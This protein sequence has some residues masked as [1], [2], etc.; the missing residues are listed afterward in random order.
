MHPILLQLAAAAVP[1]LAT[2]A[3]GF[4]ARQKDQK[5]IGVLYG[6]LAEVQK[7]MPI[8]TGELK[9]IEH[10]G[11]GTESIAASAYKTAN[12]RKPIREKASQTIF[13]TLGGFLAMIIL[14]LVPG[15]LPV[16]K[17][18]CDAAVTISGAK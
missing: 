7:N 12:G 1:A 16:V 15:A 10:R 6:V 9:R 5:Q 17:A 13:A 2:A 11:A 8:I 14:P 3:A 4:F 18:I